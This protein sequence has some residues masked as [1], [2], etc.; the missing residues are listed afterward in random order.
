MIAGET[1]DADCVSEV[2]PAP[3]RGRL[4][5]SPRPRLPTGPSGGGTSSRPPIVVGVPHKHSKKMCLG[6]K[7]LSAYLNMFTLLKLCCTGC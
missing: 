7:E 4:H 6:S 5:P 3:A 2:C 1:Q